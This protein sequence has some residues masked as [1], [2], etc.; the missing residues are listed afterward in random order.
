MTKAEIIFQ[1]LASS[2]PIRYKNYT[3][4]D[5]LMKAQKIP[6]SAK[7][8]DIIKKLVRKYPELDQIKMFTGKTSPGAV[9]SKVKK[10]TI[11]K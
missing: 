11:Y 1:K 10:V 3:A 5:L 9:Y 2:F 4:L 7:R 8:V 6:D